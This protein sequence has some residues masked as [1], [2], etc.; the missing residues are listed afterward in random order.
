MGESRKRT[1]YVVELSGGWVRV[2]KY[3]K[4]RKGGSKK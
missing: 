2:Y 4:T 1:D 3:L